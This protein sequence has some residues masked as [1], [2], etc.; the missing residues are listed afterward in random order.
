MEKLR[1]SPSGS[2]SHT[3]DFHE[4]SFYFIALEVFHTTPPGKIVRAPT[5]NTGQ[6]SPERTSRNA[7]SHENLVD[8]RFPGALDGVLRRPLPRPTRNDRTKKL[9]TKFSTGKRPSEERFDTPE[10]RAI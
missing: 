7:K 8:L 5:A 1:E 10:R 9:L 6:T 2:S 3:V 4:F